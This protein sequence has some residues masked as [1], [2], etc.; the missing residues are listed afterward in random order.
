[1]TNQFLISR[2]DGKYGIGYEIY[3]LPVGFQLRM[4]KGSKDMEVNRS[5]YTDRIFQA[6]VD[7][8]DHEIHMMNM[9]IEQEGDR[10]G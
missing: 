9:E 4:F 7:I 6:V 5:D 3:K 2:W 10:C 8:G 1:M